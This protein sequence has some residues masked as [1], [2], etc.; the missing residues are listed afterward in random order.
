[1]KL[2]SFDANGNRLSIYD[3][4]PPPWRGENPN[5]SLYHCYR[6]EMRHAEITENIENLHY[7]T[8]WELVV[9]L[10]G[11]M[12]FVSEARSFSLKRG[13]VI[14]TPPNK[15]HEYQLLRHSTLFKYHIFCFE[16]DAF[17]PYRCGNLTDKIAAVKEPCVCSTSDHNI[18]DA[19]LLAL[20]RMHYAAKNKSDPLSVQAMSVAYA[21][22]SFYYINQYDFSAQQSKKEPPTGI[23]AMQQYLDE[24]FT[25][26]N[27]INEVAERFF[28]SREYVYRLFKRHLNTTVADYIRQKRVAKSQQLIAA[29]T[30]LLSACYQV[31][32]DHP[33]T[34]IRAFRA[35]TGMTPSQYRKTLIIS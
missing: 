27:S 9:F 23:A 24:H 22:Q 20:E 7:H 1:M 31:G 6:N 5:T 11:E 35:V 16:L 2:K 18:T 32:Y 25:E 28:Y 15:L 14:I 21:M 8:Y 30:P 17:V 3:S 29:G 19:L 34:F 26:I 4:S 33:S 10:E 13:D 12:Q